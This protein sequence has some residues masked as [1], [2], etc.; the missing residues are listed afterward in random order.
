[1]QKIPMGMI[2]QVVDCPD[3]RGTG[4]TI[5]DKDKCK[6]C[7]GQK[8][9]QEKKALEVCVERG[10]PDGKRYTFSGESDEVPDVTPGDVIV[11]IAIEKHPRF[12]RKGADL[13]HKIDINIMQALTG[14]E[15]VLE[16][17]DK[18]KVMIKTSPGQIIQPGVFMT[19][20]E[21]GLPFYEKTFAHGNLFI[22]FNIVFPDRLSKEQVEH[23]N[24]AFPSLIPKKISEKIDEVYELYEYDINQENTHHAGGKKD[25]RMDEDDDEENSHGGRR[26]QCQN[27]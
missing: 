9:V 1:M 2:Q 23:L 26:V 11:E 14:F 15:Y 24:K 16:H 12:L 21:L 5:K 27:Q 3:C 10:A 18:R 7:N 4:T 25:N 6:Q 22:D 20:K 13:V 17:L 19:C 8:A